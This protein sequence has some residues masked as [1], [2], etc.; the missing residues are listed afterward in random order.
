MAVAG[1]VVAGMGAVGTAMAGMEAVGTAAGAHAVGF[2]DLMAGIGS[3]V[4]GE[5]WNG[6]ELPTDIWHGPSLILL[7]ERFLFDHLIG[8]DREA[9]STRQG[10]GFAPPS[11]ARDAQSG[12]PGLRPAPP[13]K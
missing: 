6:S 13:L 7:F 11:P 4:A 3:G 10:A 5:C 12:S 9:L 1:T 8:S 2:Q